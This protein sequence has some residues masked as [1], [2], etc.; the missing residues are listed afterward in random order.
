MA[1]AG[2]G[3]QH[4][5][6]DHSEDSQP[7][8]SIDYGFMRDTEDSEE[9]DC[10]PILVMR[11]R[12]TQGYA[13][14][15]VDSKGVNDYAL[16]FVIGYVRSLGWKRRTFKSDNEEALLALKRRVTENL[17]GVEVIPEESPVGD[18]SAKGE[19]E[20]AVREV[21]RKV[22]CIKGSLEEYLGFRLPFNHPMLTWLPRHAADLMSKKK[23]DQTATPQRS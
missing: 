15:V 3:S 9:E 6:V 7:V 8:L 13:A 19:A 5:S 14:S 2:I 10:L 16:K 23:L 21:K 18:H 1:V 17:V 4:R 12:K 22:R 20:N 11:D